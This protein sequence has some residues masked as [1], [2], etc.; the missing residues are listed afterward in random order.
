MKRLIFLLL[1]GLSF[2]AHAFVILPQGHTPQMG[3]QTRT[4]T[5]A[6]QTSSGQTAWANPANAEVLDGVY[7]T[8]TGSGSVLSETLELSGASFSVPPEATITGFQVV[9]TRHYRGAETAIEGVISLEK[10]GAG[11]SSTAAD[12][13]AWLTTDD[14]I[15][16]GGS[17]DLWGL[18]WAPSNVN[19]ASFGVNYSVN[20]TGWSTT[21]AY[22]DCITVTVYYTV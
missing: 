7:A 1:W 11:A 3:S 22:I 9:V 18:P 19:S 14:S 13:V 5:V 20:G 4:F 12:T 6:N 16:S 15:N 2:C 21:T 17:T 8:V 10:G